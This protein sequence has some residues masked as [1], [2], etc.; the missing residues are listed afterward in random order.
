MK[1]SRVAVR[2]RPD[3]IGVCLQSAKR[4]VD[5]EVGTVKELEGRHTS[6]WTPV[7]HAFTS[8]VPPVLVREVVAR[9]LAMP[10]S[11]DAAGRDELCPGTAALHD[12]VQLTP[13]NE[14]AID[15]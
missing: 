14:T 15:V 11:R 3:W 5:V 10:M 13:V 2:M 1:A 7:D 6:K 12:A 8:G 4:A 9:I